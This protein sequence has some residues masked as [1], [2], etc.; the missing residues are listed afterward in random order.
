MGPRGGLLFKLLWGLLL[1]IRIGRYFRL[2]ANNHDLRCFAGGTDADRELVD[3]AFLGEML[4]VVGEFRGC[5]KRYARYFALRAFEMA[6][7]FEDNAG[8]WSYRDEPLTLVE[9]VQRV[10]ADAHL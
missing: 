2:A 10:R 3:R 1:V 8:S 5:R 4:D 9:I 6:N 7:E